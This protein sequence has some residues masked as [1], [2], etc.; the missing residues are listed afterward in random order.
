MGQGISRIG[1]A[2]KLKNIKTRRFG[3]DLL[4]EGDVK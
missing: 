2:F 3:E 4:L 1:R